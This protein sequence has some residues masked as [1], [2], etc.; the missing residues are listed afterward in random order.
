MQQTAPRAARAAAVGA[1]QQMLAVREKT[2]LQTPVVVRV[3]VQPSHQHFL[4]AEQVGQELLLLLT[5]ILFLHQLQ[6]VAV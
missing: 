2:E 5:L 1:A 4:V 3:E 6:L